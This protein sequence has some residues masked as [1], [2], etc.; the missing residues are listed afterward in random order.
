MFIDRTVS[1]FILLSSI[2][3]VVDGCNNR[4]RKASDPAP[5][6]D[7][8]ESGEGHDADSRKPESA[9]SHRLP[10]DRS[11]TEPIVYQNPEISNGLVAII[12]LDRTRTNQDVFLASVDGD[13]DVV[14]NIRYKVVPASDPCGPLATYS[15]SQTPSAEL[16]KIPIADLN[17]GSYVLCALAGDQ[18]GQW[19]S[20]DLPTEAAFAIDRTGPQELS[21]G[22]VAAADGELKVAW[23][24][25][26]G[27]AEEFEVLL[28]QIGSG[29]AEVDWSTKTSLNYLEEDAVPG[30]EF[31]LCLVGFDSLGNPSDRLLYGRVSMPSS[32]S[33][34]AITGPIHQRQLH[35]L[36][37]RSDGIVSETSQVIPID[38]ATG[39]YLSGRVAL[40]LDSQNVASYVYKIETVQDFSEPL[41]QVMRAVKDG[42]RWQEKLVV[43][44]N[45]ESSPGN[46][47][48]GIGWNNEEWIVHVD[49][50]QSGSRVLLTHLN[51]LSS[52]VLEE[53]DTSVNDTAILVKSNGQP[54]TAIA[55]QEYLSFVATSASDR[56][57]TIFYEDSAC[58]NYHSVN[59]IK[60]KSGLATAYL[61]SIAAPDDDMADI[62]PSPRC[63]LRLARGEGDSLEELSQSWTATTVATI[64]EEYL[65]SPFNTFK[66]GVALS[67]NGYAVLVYRKYNRLVEDEP[68]EMIEIAQIDGSELATATIASADYFDSA[69]VVALDINDRAHVFYIGNGE[70]NYLYETSN[71]LSF[72]SIPI[73][74]SPNFSLDIEDLLEMTDPRIVGLDGIHKDQ[75]SADS[76]T[77]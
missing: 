1:R 9:D 26:N 2:A 36:V 61:C 4:P 12:R 23:T 65:C 38:E 58:S 57:E 11:S 13:F 63:E 39:G 75:T 48:S 50:H 41:W 74:P 25:P 19:Q 76:I 72:S 33:I 68:A 56:D 31:D 77:L 24:D 8:G 40:Q 54:I 53:L 49:L 64:D 10:V 45:Q 32:I 37:L 7:Q 27:E 69:P 62:Q 18:S 66:P 15:S 29:C 14:A 34:G 22:D 52:K 71:K 3:F 67:R 5:L 20:A 6:I 51:D 59:L 21:F 73:S 60:T 43:S 46:Q 44:G 42:D 55:T 17:D 30:G 16:F 70:L 47:I 35:H 28:T